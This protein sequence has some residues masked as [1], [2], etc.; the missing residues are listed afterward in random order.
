[1]Q[2]NRKMLAECLQILKWN[3]KW[4][5]TGSTN[6]EPVESLNVEDDQESCLKHDACKDKEKYQ[7]ELIDF[8]ISFTCDAISDFLADIMALYVSLMVSSLII[9]HIV[10]VS[11]VAK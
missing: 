3:I 6:P 1:M 9:Y 11:C 5:W 8:S 10:V 4:S 7:A 2:I